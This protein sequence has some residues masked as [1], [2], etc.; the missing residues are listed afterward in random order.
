MKQFNVETRRKATSLGLTKQITGGWDVAVNFKREDKDGTKL[1][2]AP[3]QI[4]GA[5]TRGTL[6]APEPINYTTDLFDA[7]ARYTGEKLQMQVNYHASQFKNSNQ[8]LTFDNL[9]YNPLSTVG[10]S[11]LIGRLGQMP[12]NELH[13]LS[14][15]GGYSF[16]KETRLSGNL[17]FGR[18][19]QNEAFLPY[20][21]SSTLVATTG[22]PYTLAGLPATSLNGKVETTHLDIK[23]NT[24]LMHD[25][26]LTPAQV[27]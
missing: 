19:T 2:G 17:S 3:F 24:K 13:Q 16:S 4:A 1:T 21:T 11:T 12:D 8:S 18:L 22:T 26:H 25:L 6:L 23:L 5:G 14:A 27:R 15:T 9:Y 7:T 20:T 10:G